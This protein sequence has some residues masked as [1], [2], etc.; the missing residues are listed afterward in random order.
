MRKKCLFIFKI[1]GLNDLSLTYEYSILPPP[2]FMCPNDKKSAFFIKKRT[3]LSMPAG[4]SCKQL[5]RNGVFDK[6][7]KAFPYTANFSTVLLVYLSKTFY[8]N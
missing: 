6:L 5:I 4:L 2:L 1:S 8:S 7:D 3:I